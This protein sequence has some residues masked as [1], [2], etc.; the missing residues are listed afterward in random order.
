MKLSAQRAVHPD[1]LQGKMGQRCAETGSGPGVQGLHATIPA[2][3]QRPYSQFLTRGAGPGDQTKGWGRWGW[4]GIRGRRFAL[5]TPALE[6]HS[7]ATSSVSQTTWHIG[8]N[9]RYQELQGI[10]AASNPSAARC[11]SVQLCTRGLQ[12]QARNKHIRVV[13]S[14][15][16]HPLLPVPTCLVAQLKYRSVLTET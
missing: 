7:Q 8:Y 15:V 10:Q 16:C 13:K 6:L 9:Q 5:L 2:G 12:L 14:D 4:A 11:R 3:R 1:T